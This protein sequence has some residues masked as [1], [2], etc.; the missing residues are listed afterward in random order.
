[1]FRRHRCLYLQRASTSNV[2]T[3]RCTEPCNNVRRH[4]AASR[5]TQSLYTESAPF[6]MSFKISTAKSRRSSTQMY[7]FGKV[8][9]FKN[10]HV[11]AQNLNF[12]H[13]KVQLSLCLY[14][15]PILGESSYSSIHSYPP[16]WTELSGPFHTRFALPTHK[17][18]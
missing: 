17:Q 8:R 12:I 14:Q 18:P 10:S 2:Q 11:D 15:N 3:Q 6:K 5:R 1:M 16:N 9:S 4:H 7:L 13:T